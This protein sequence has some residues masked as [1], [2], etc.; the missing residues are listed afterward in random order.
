MKAKV[1]L[2]CAMTLFGSIGLFVKFIDLSSGA[3]ALYR[4]F[5]GSLFLIAAT[6][7]LKKPLNWP[8][9][10]KN[11]WVLA[12]S[13]AAIGLNWIFLFQAY[14]YTTIANATLSY[15]FA[16]VFVVLL[17]PLVLREKLSLPRFLALVTA[18]CGLFLV[19]GFDAM[20]GTNLWFGLG[21][22]L[23]AAAFY[24]AVILLNKFVRSLSGLET[25]LIQ[26]IVAAVT[27]LPY[28][29]LTEGLNLGGLD[30][31]SLVFVLIIGVVHTG[32][33]Y[34]LYFSAL[35]NLPGQTVA[36]LSYIDPVSAIIMA[37][38]FLGETL[39][40]VQIIGATL[41]LGATLL[42]E[43]YGNRRP[44][45]EKGQETYNIE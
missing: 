38:I 20:P 40:P 19:V 1:M 33:G 37:A 25:T 9:I 16:P 27:L 32:F 8:G 28:I 3:I 29:L 13:G 18:V 24:A 31:R 14:K 5:L 44:L 10:K 12:L 11:L 26:L 21:Y 41:I 17:S 36:S 4:G 2:I 22:G 45:A 39:G 35:Q 23:L 6:L 43:R 34:F 7:A 30:T 42:G 15:Y